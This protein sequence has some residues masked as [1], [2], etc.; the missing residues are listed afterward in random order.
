MLTQ[1]TQLP[2]VRFCLVVTSDGLVDKHTPEINRDRADPIAAACSA[3]LAGAI[4]VEEAAG[5][6]GVFQQ[7]FSHWSDGY[8]F[9]R[10]AGNRSSL[11]VVTSEDVDPGL[12]ARAMAERIKQIGEPTLSAPARA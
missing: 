3:L 11:A 1:L 9:I 7:V 4:A 10:R 5:V 8:L 12:I 2:G 6:Q